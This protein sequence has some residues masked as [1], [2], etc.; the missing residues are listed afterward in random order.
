M[1]GWLGTSSASLGSK[2]GLEVGNAGFPLAGLGRGWGMML[3]G[4]QSLATCPSQTG[5]SLGTPSPLVL[6]TLPIREANSIVED[7]HFSFSLFLL[8]DGWVHLEIIQGAWVECEHTT[9]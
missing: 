8:L 2:L 5:L 4:L 9:P 6:L 1:S 3:G 7:L